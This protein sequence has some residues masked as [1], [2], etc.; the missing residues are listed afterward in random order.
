[1]MPQESDP[2]QNPLRAKLTDQVKNLAEEALKPGGDVSPDSLAKAERL[3]QLVQL[4]NDLKPRAPS[5]RWTAAALLAATVAIASV[6]LLAHVR[7]TEIELNLAVSEMRFTVDSRQQLTDTLQ[8]ASLGASGLSRVVLPGGDVSGVPVP[9]LRLAAAAGAVPAA[10]AAGTISLEP[11]I[12]P[13]HSQMTLSI[14]DVPGELR[15]SISRLSEAL[16]ADTNGSVHV[17]APRLAQKTLEAGTPQPVVLTPG[18]SEVRLDLAPLSAGAALFAPGLTIT[19]MTL[20]HI[21]EVS[22]DDSTAVRAVSTVQSGSVLL[23]EL[24][25]RE[26]KLRAHEELRFAHARG[27]IRSIGLKDG[28]LALNF[29]GR[30]RGMATGPL[31]HPRNLMPRWLDWLRANQPLSLLWGSAIYLFGLTTAVRQWWKK[32]D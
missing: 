21:D 31:E 14:G 4:Q 28:S 18:S 17:A 9:G 30:V 1:M 19:D 6:L 5:S 22:E 13:A 29:H 20:M 12:A 2:S 16:R 7:E 23:E 25:D 32:N 8:L 27:E 10:A 11:I 26:L 15:L 3:V 24:G